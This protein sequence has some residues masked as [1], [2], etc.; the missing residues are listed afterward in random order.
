[1]ALSSLIYSK[2]PKIKTLKIGVEYAGGIIFYID[3][4]GKHGKV[5]STKD[6]GDLTWFEAYNSCKNLMLNGFDDWYL[7]SIYE[8]NLIYSIKG[9]IDQKY[10]Y[11][12]WTTFDTKFYW[13]SSLYNEGTATNCAWRFEF[14]NGKSEY[15]KRGGKDYYSLAVRAVRN[16]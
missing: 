4:S 10:W 9:E 13:S 8:L 6:I 16:F 7:P 1:M 11:S 14:N 15:Y 3:P 12:Q 2:K 5:M